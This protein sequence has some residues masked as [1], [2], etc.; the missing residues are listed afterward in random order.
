MVGSGT[1]H[2]SSV[3]SGEGVLSARR[4]AVKGLR[5]LFN[6]NTGLCKVQNDV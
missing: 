1:R 5:R 4:A 2:I 3:T 6:K